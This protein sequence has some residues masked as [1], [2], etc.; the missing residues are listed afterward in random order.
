M[1]HEVVLAGVAVSLLAMPVLLV[2][3]ALVSRKILKE[4]D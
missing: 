4:E 2:L 3:I 1:Y